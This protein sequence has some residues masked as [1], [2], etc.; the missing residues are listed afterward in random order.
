MKRDIITIDEDLCTGCG[1][2]IPG[3]PEGA[4]QIIEG[5]AR[6]VS[7]LFCDGLGAC[8]GECP[9]KAIKVEKREAEPY[10]EE[11]V[12]GNVVPHGEATIRA[13]LG[14][15]QKHG[16]TGFLEI[17]LGYLEKNNLPILS[18][19]KGEK[20]PG[21]EPV[22][23]CGCPGT[24]AQEIKHEERNG[25]EDDSVQ[26]RSELTQWPVQ[27]H[28]LN[29]HAPYLK[30]AD[31]LVAADCVPFSYGNFHRDFLRGKKLIIFCPK[32]DAGIDVYIEKLTAI[33]Q[34]QNIRSLQLVH[35]EVPCCFGVGQIV[36]KAMREAG[37]K[38]TVTDITVSIN[39][40]IQS[41]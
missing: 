36:E 40:E 18:G 10:D 7:D 22:M 20:T 1:Q 4:L 14:H 24:M 16:E 27:L 31:L 6:L 32:L 28:L 34:S 39:G 13:H 41:N 8:I 21:E 9:E 12:M 23:A 29:P 26:V 2:C 37:V 17:A 33:F 5:K 3:C 38:I 19:F 15:L 11:K 35:M 30:D 25:D